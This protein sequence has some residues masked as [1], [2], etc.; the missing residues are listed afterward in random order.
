MKENSKNHR[1][2]R[3]K[4]LIFASFGVL[5]LGSLPSCSHTVE[6]IIPDLLLIANE[7]ERQPYN[8]VTDESN[9]NA[10][11]IDN[12]Y[13]TYTD[14]YDVDIAKIIRD[15]LN[16]E[17]AIIQVQWESIITDLQYG[18]V[19]LVVGGM[20]DTPERRE[21]IAFTDEYY[22]SEMVM[23]TQKDVA[24]RYEGQVLD[25]EAFA[26]FVK[27]QTVISMLATICD[28]ITVYFAEKYGLHRGTPLPTSADCAL[29]IHS[30]V[31]FGYLEEY[32]SAAVLEKSYDNIGIVHF[33]QDLFAKEPQFGSYGVSI[34][35]R[36]GMNKL[37]D[38]LN[39]MLADLSLE[40][41]DELMY[42]A[43]ERSGQ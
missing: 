13:G 16:V 43:I 8:W 5:L 26:A 9:P 17:V 30:G 18:A 12:H 41:R 28:D 11:P 3:T 36:K 31:A 20:T 1:K 35:L 6:D 10:L 19:D 39:D 23:V 14:G 15:T 2:T 29:D 33:D 34:G 24:E 40:K 38:A 27:D 7:C 25:E 37:K 4:G 21:V 22:K 32:T 42:A